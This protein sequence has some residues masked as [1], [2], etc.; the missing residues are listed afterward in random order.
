[1]SSMIPNRAKMGRRA[2]IPAIVLV[3]LMLVGCGGSPHFRVETAGAVVF[4][5][6]KA[7]YYHDSLHGNLTASGTPYDKNA[8]T[9]AHRS[10]PFGTRVLVRNEKNG[11]TL[12]V[13]INDRG[14]FVRGRIIDLSRRGAKELGFLQDGVVPVTIS[15]VK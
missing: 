15:I 8:L 6:G 10:L 2:L 7:S 14:P 13:V 5:R 3:A 11:R 4:Q 12:K 1:M 9:A